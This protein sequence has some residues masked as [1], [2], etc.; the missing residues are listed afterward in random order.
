[1]IDFGVIMNQ[2]T[3]MTTS[4]YSIYVGFNVTAVYVTPNYPANLTTWPIIMGAEY[5]F[6]K[7]I[8]IG[9][10]S[11]LFYYNSAVNNAFFVI[12][13]NLIFLI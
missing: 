9:Q 4:A 8:W 11:T 6:G 5:Y 13:N 3:S 7:E 10:Y 12:H 1:M 2:N